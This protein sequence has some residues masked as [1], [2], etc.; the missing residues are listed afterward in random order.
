MPPAE[1]P[2]PMRR[3]R[4]D[5]QDGKASSTFRRTNAQ[6]TKGQNGPRRIQPNEA[7]SRTASLQTVQMVP[8]STS[9]FPER[10]GTLT[11]TDLRS[12]CQITQR[13]E[14]WN[15]GGPPSSTAGR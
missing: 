13:T 11:G 12:C 5:G 8:S 2:I 10:D 3:S 15:I 4:Q 9:Y 7:Q 1:K 14:E 6:K